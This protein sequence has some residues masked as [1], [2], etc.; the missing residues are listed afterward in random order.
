MGL[1]G[2][3]RRQH[4]ADRHFHVCPVE[5]GGHRC[6]QGVAG[7]AG[8]G[9]RSGQGQIITR[10]RS[11]ATL[12][13]AH[14]VG[15]RR[16][17]VGSGNVLH[18]HRLYRG[19]WPE[20][21][22]RRPVTGCHAHRGADC[23]GGDGANPVLFFRAVRSPGAQNHLPLGR[24]PDRPVGLCPVS[25]HRYRIAAPDC[26]GDHPGIGLPRY[27]VRPPGS[28]FYRA[29]YHRS[30]LLGRLTGLSDRRH[31]RRRAG[32]DHRGAAVE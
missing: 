2:S 16:V 32:A 22:N 11:P 3:V 4:R 5:A 26:V 28:V 20:L 25:P 6:I 23:L 30:T 7:V 13:Q 12:S 29:V 9:S 15:S 27:A 18:P 1:A 21:A 31:C 24:H 8:G 17:P 14:H 10:Y 19:L